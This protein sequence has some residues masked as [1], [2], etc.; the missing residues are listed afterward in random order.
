MD[1]KL[2]KIR[3]LSSLLIVSIFLLFFIYLKEFII[4][5]FL[6]IY[7]AIF[8]EIYRNFTKKKVVIYLYIY[9]ILS[10][11]SL[12][13]YF[14]LYFNISE[15]IFVILIITIFDTFSYLIGSLYG[16]K[17]IFKQVSPNKSY[18][19]LFGGVVFTCIIILFINYLF[20][21]MEYNQIFYIIPIY[22]FLSFW[23]DIIESSFKRISII[24]N[25]SNFIPGHGGIFDR[26]DSFILCAYG[27]YF[28]NLL[29]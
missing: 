6:L 5:L 16:S 10:F 29:F 28:S 1:Y 8:I 15:L 23:G 19:G 24:K 11:I 13:F 25:S 12:F 17:K 7:I 14:N 2:L 22:I 4:I 9:L 26:F 20:N 27:L 18:L 21:L 3:F